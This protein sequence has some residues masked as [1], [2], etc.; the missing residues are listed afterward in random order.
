MRNRRGRKTRKRGGMKAKSSSF[1][2]R[3]DMARKTAEDVKTGTLKP[4]GK[5]GL[6]PIPVARKAITHTN[7][8]E[9]IPVVEGVLVK[10]ARN[11]SSNT[12]NFLLG[13]TRGARKTGDFIDRINE[14]PMPKPPTKPP[15]SKPPVKNRTIKLK[16]AA[17]LPITNFND[18]KTQE[19]IANLKSLGISLPANPMPPLPPSTMTF[20]I[21]VK[22]VLEDKLNDIT[23]E[24]LSPD[25]RSEFCLTQIDAS[26]IKDEFVIANVSGFELTIPWIKLNGCSPIL[27]AATF[28]LV[29]PCKQIIE[30]VSNEN[31]IILLSGCDS[32][33]NNALSLCAQYGYK[34]LCEY[35]I[36]EHKRLGIH[37]EG[38]MWPSN[39]YGDCF[40]KTPLMLAAECGHLEL[41][42]ILL[43]N[44]ANPLAK[45]DIHQNTLH[46]CIIKCCPTPSGYKTPFGYILL[47][48]NEWSQY[49]LAHDDTYKNK[50]FVWRFNRII[51]LLLR[52]MIFENGDYSAGVYRKNGLKTALE[53]D[54]NG[55]NKTNVWDDSANNGNGAYTHYTLTNNS[56]WMAYYYLRSG[57]N[58]V[59]HSLTIQQSE[60]LSDFVDKYRSPFIQKTG[61]NKTYSSKTYSS[62]DYAFKSKLFTSD[63]DTI[64]PIIKNDSNMFAELEKGF[65]RDIWEKTTSKDFIHYFL[66]YLFYE[67]P[68]PKESEN[69]K[70][71][72]LLSI[73]RQIYLL[74][75]NQ[76]NLKPFVPTNRTLKSYK[77]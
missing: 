66:R 33:G 72:K 36:G 70:I 67:E 41:I 73:K 18:P 9:A 37:L 68:I 21:F 76:H 54:D 24:Q 2:N 50:E 74:K 63:A 3:L 35:L 31:Q 26:A 1:K 19:M 8:A 49:D 60:G 65:N 43:R 25:K 77:K 71:Q 46:H 61:K 11:N 55:K 20:P 57:H 69:D 39:V 14:T 16:P 40:G 10:S 64:V 62:G 45:N 52:F 5:V 34:S 53:N 56:N 47:N 13:N 51:H 75:I 4:Q 12:D 38:Y 7:V 48:T 30:Y 17:P 29:Q 42:K 59:F 28:G 44:G 27:V 23:D 58:K 32:F 22:A 15:M 6:V